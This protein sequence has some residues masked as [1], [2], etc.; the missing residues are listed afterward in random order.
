MCFEHF[1]VIGVLKRSKEAILEKMSNTTV[2]QVLCSFFT[3]KLHSYPPFMTI[4]DRG[5]LQMERRGIQLICYHYQYMTMSVFET[6]HYIISGNWLFLSY[7]TFYYK[8]NVGKT[9]S[10]VRMNLIL[11][12]ICKNLDVHGWVGVHRFGASICIC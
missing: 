11:V 1:D 8:I 10:V 2:F 9:N 4:I 7:K 5:N 3:V 12:F 6:N